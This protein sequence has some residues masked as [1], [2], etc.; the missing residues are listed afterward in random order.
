MA[1]IAAMT[2]LGVLVAGLNAPA[3][4]QGRK[5][6]GTVLNAAS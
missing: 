3:G 1:R 4:A 2:V 6:S 5:V